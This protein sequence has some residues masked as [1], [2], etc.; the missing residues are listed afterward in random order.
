[1]VIT[2][3]ENKKIKRYIKLKDKKYRDLYDEFLIE[4]EH[5]V[6][7]AYKKNIIK[8]ILLLGEEEY[9]IGFSS[10]LFLPLFIMKKVTNLDSP[11]KVCAICSKMK[12]DFECRGNYLLLDRIQDPGN[13]GTIIRSAVAFHIDMIILS[14]DTVDLYNSKVIR[15]TQGMLF[16][17]PIVRKDLLEVLLLLRE[18]GYS[19]YTTDVTGGVDIRDL[20]SVS[21]TRFAL[22]VGNEGE[23]VRT[24]LA[25]LC[26]KR[27]YIPMNKKVESLNVAVASSILL[28]EMGRGGNR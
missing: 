28:Y 16:Q 13:L 15:A 14:L 26:D 20:D 19:T 22:L 5:L 3:L 10:V 6:R 12:S 17:V 18:K 11:P 24:E 21:K 27:V 23:G 4:G 25:E 9:D 8:E 1:M 7:E 2:S